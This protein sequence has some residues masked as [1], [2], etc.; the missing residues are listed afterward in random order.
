LAIRLTIE[1]EKCTGCQLCAIYCGVRHRGAVDPSRANVAVLRNRAEHIRVPFTCFQCPDAACQAACPTEAI[2]RDTATGAL[3]V[4]GD[5]CTACGACVAACPYGNM[6]LFDGD[7]AASKCDLCGGRPECA[8]VCPQHAITVAEGASTEEDIT[9]AVE[10][11]R[12][13]LGEAPVRKEGAA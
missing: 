4:D 13:A 8:S 1:A 5:L 2:G 7:D 10:A 12:T 6:Q 11:A 3:T 9:A